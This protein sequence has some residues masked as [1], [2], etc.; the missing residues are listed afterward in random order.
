MGKQIE[1][2]MKSLKEVNFEEAVLEM[3]D[4]FMGIDDKDSICNIQI[5]GRTVQVQLRLIDEDE[6]DFNDFH[7]IPLVKINQ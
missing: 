4:N 7:G 3:V 5:D 6:S 1:N 2:D